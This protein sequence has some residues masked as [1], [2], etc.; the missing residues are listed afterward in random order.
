EAV[1]TLARAGGEP[2]PA[3]AAAPRAGQRSQACGWPEGAVVEAPDGRLIAPV[4]D[5]ASGDRRCAGFWP[6]VEGWHR[7]RHGERERWFHVA[8][9]DADPTLRLAEL[10][11]ATLALAAAAP[12]AAARARAVA[13]PGVPGPAWPWFVLW[14]AVAGAAWGLE[15]S[16][17]GPRAVATPWRTRR[18][19]ARQGLTPG[20]RAP[21]CRRAGR[22]GGAPRRGPRRRRARARL[23]RPA[24]RARPGP[25]SCCGWRWRAR[26]GGWNVRAG[27]CAPSQRHDVRAGRWHGRGSP[28]ARASVATA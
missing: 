17:R 27:A 7:L 14:L 19:G 11:E 18:P 8:A 9:A 16:R 28:P 26:P 10:R 22:R 15:R 4:A 21:R 6:R 20:A 13:A 2:L 25:G 1:A 23:P 3:F 24:S 12:D 5:P